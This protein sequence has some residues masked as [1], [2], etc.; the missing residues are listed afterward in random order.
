[1]YR[2]A[3]QAEACATGW[4]T[5]PVPASFHQPFHSDVPTLLI[6]G[7]LDPVTPPRW[8]EAAAAML[9]NHLHVVVPHAGHGYNGM[10]GTACIDS[11]V[12]RF[13]RQ[14]SVQG[15]D[16]SSCVQG[17]RPPPFV[18]GVREP[19]TLERAAVEKFAGT[20]AATQPPLEVR[21]EALDRVLRVTIGG[22]FTAISSPLSATEFNVEGLP[23]GYF[24][25]FSADGQTV[26]LHEPGGKPL[27]L[28]RK[29]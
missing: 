10:E 26:T 7:E 15:L 22:D 17:V 4:P 13:F 27:V 29:P 14:G 18:T 9:P 28:T 24:I 3:Q 12:M 19:I 25:V 20:Y 2:V 21:V 5:Y 1:D 6:S 8:G 11:L 16:A 23:P